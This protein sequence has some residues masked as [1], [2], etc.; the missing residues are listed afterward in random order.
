MPV[1]SAYSCYS[2]YVLTIDWL[3]YKRRCLVGTTLSPSGVF[4]ISKKGRGKFRWPLICSYK[5]GGKP[6]FPNFFHGEKK[7]FLAK[8]G[9][10]PMPPKYATAIACIF[11]SRSDVMNRFDLGDERSLA[12]PCARFVQ[13]PEWPHGLTNFFVHRHQ[14]A[15][16]LLTRLVSREGIFS[17]EKPEH[18]FENNINIPAAVV[19]VGDLITTAK[20]YV[21]QNYSALT[22]VESKI[23]L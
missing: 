19:C 12:R 6:C 20:G 11:R 15:P 16:L 5:G 2:F 18:T 4:R 22:T 9:H 3:A 23:I 21:I 14:L 10:G 7:F 13:T 8:G 17:Y 1:R